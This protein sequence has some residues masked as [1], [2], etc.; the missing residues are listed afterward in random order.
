MNSAWVYCLLLKSQ[1]MLLGEKKK[2]ERNANLDPQQ[3]LSIT[4]LNFYY[5]DVCVYI[6]MYIYIHLKINKLVYHIS[7]NN[8]GINDMLVEI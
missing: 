2:K 7:Y 3:I 6:F 4:N 5:L 1:N 8:N